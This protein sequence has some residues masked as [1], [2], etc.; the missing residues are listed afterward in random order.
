MNPNTCVSLHTCKNHQGKPGKP[1]KVKA[2]LIFYIK[3]KKLKKPTKT[4]IIDETKRSII[5]NLN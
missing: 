5:K 4:L 3:I 1:V 2:K